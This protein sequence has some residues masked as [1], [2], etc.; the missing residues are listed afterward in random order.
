MPT[1]AGG[2]ST[3]APIGGRGRAPR[4]AAVGFQGFGNVG[5]EAILAG[6]EALLDGRVE[7]TTIFAGRAAPVPAFPSAERVSTPRH[8]PTLAAWRRLR[9]VDALVVSGGGLVND[10]WPMV[11]PRYAL[12]C[13]VAR[14]AGARV[15]W[16]AAGVGP[17]RRRPWRWMAGLGFRLSRLVT[18]RDSAS[19]RWVRRCHR[20]ARVV[21]VPDPAFFI[22]PPAVRPTT[23]APPV[24][25]APGG[26]A[27]VARGPAP[28]SSLTAERL[29]TALAD[30]AAWACAGGRQVQV[31]V[32]HAAEDGRFLARLGAT[33]R[34]RGLGDL[35]VASPETPE[36]AIALLETAA[37]VVTVRLHGLI[38]AAVAGVPS[39][40]VAYDPKVAEAAAALGLADLAVA[41][42]DVSGPALVATLDRLLADPDRRERLA[43]TT[44]AIRSRGPAVADVLVR[45]MA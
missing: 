42:A 17:I 34:A 2:S 22:E 8:L 4:I 7:L 13:L 27:I 31:V 37:A 24:A 44:A 32:L 39:V 43:A 25:A 26:V 10:Y 38:L 23:G 20:G 9:R 5:D 28:D 16:I 15:I 14:L 40:A 36:R 3:V 19:E 18:V 29:A 41:T 21:V 35:P 33:L 12:W 45:A 1:M 11:I 6:L 30:V